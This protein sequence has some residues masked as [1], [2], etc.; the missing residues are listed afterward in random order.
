GKFYIE[1]MKSR[2]GTTVN[3]KAV[4]T[5]TLLREN[6][7]IKICD[8]VLSF[9]EKPPLPPDDIPPD[10]DEE[11]DSSTVE[12]TLSGGSSRQIL[13]AQPAEKLALLVDI[14]AELSQ[15][16]EI[17]ELLPKIADSLFNVFRQADRGFIILGEGGKLIPKVT[18]AR[19]G[20][21][22]ATPRFSRK[23]VNRCLETGQSVLSEDAS[24]DK[25]FD[26]S[27]SIAD[28]RIRS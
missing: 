18:K 22:D 12:A 17:D 26:L 24:S 19:R 27:Q 20:G 9:H 28:A 21:D 11:E 25:Q 6:D 3:D 14:G 13:E 7:K 23:I 8:F 5:R 1:D 2:N 4:T 16:L 15:N 10:D